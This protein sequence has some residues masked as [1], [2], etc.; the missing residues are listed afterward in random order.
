[1]LSEIGIKIFD[2]EIVKDKINSVYFFDPLNKKAV[3]KRIT[4]DIELIAGLKSI[5]QTSK[6]Y[7]YK[8]QDATI[9]KTG[10]GLN[11]YLFYVNKDQL[12]KIKNVGLLGTKKHVSFED[13]NHGIAQHVTLKHNMIKVRI[14]LTGL[15]NE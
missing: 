5:G 8:K 4:K 15:K 13:Y 11:K 10:K 12:I 14:E 7:Y 2:F 3:V 6:K 1:M 9:Y